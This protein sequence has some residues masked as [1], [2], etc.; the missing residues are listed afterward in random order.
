MLVCVVHVWVTHPPHLPEFGEHD[1]DG[2]VMFPEHPPEVLGGLCQ[3]ALCGHVGSLL[4][5]QRKDQTAACLQ[6]MVTL[7]S[8]CALM[9]H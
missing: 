5:A 9:N 3:G 4:P 6:V 2:G 1:D 7:N 8:K